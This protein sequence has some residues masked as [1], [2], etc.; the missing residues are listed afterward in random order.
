MYVRCFVCIVKK[1]LCTEFPAFQNETS[2]PSVSC[3]GSMEQTAVT[4]EG[5]TGVSGSEDPIL[6]MVR[7]YV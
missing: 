3:H 6:R 7:L 4:S 5:E 2:V 1:A